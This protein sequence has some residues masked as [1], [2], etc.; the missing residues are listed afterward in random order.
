MTLLKTEYKKTLTSQGVN[1]HG[2][3][4]EL[5]LTNHRHVALHLSDGFEGAEGY[6]L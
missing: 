6:V 3:Q 5:V 2:V 4:N 1:V